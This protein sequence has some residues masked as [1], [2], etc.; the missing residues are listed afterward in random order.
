MTTIYANCNALIQKPYTSEKITKLGIPI[1]V[2]SN[3]NFSLDDLLRKLIDC[4]SI[5]MSEFKVKFK[6]ASWKYSLYYKFP[7]A[8]EKRLKI[9]D[10]YLEDRDGDQILFNLF[11]IV[12][13]FKENF[14]SIKFVVDQ[15]YDKLE[16]PNFE[17]QLTEED[18][19]FYVSLITK[20]NRCKFDYNKFENR[21]I[22]YLA[23][24][25]FKRL[26]YGSFA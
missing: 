16:D 18:S 22:T 6:M 17:I 21:E 10:D 14:P 15:L 4:G 8:K 11:L 26:K 5:T 3:L 24:Y 20:A 1:E 9:H 7:F 2:D 19:E 25:C 12:Q 13:P 23:E